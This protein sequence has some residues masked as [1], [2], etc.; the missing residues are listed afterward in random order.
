MTQRGWSRAQIRRACDSQAGHLPR[1]KL[2]PQGKG[3]PLPSPAQTTSSSKLIRSKEQTQTC[4][5]KNVLRKKILC[6]HWPSACF[7]FGVLGRLLEANFS[8]ITKSKTTPRRSE[9]VP[10]RARNKPLLQRVSARSLEIPGDAPRI[11][12]SCI[13]SQPSPSPPCPR[14]PQPLGCQQPAPAP[15]G[16]AGPAPRTEQAGQP[17]WDAVAPHPSQSLQLLGFWAPGPGLRPTPCKDGMYSGTRSWRKPETDKERKAPEGESFLISHHAVADQLKGRT[18]GTHFRRALLVATAR[19][20]GLAVSQNDPNT[21]RT[22]PFWSRLENPPERV[23]ALPAAWENVFSKLKGVLSS[24]PSHSGCELRSPVPREGGRS[25]REESSLCPSPLL[26]EPP[27]RAG[28]SPGQRQWQSC[29]ITEGRALC[30]RDQRRGARS[31][32]ASWR[33]WLLSE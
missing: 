26:K 32:K 33:R 25:L 8:P 24:F 21:L 2:G 7:H 19:E 11:G 3:E 31:R 18:G 4:F 12:T 1:D 28:D 9:P 10:G 17:P 6:S 30:Y 22:G 15:H 27:P 13:H 16:H 14:P 20:V 23:G 29:R 5:S